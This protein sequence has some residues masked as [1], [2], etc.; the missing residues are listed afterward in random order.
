MIK[1]D[2]NIS[3]EAMALCGRVAEKT[4]A[5]DE[6]ALATE[7]YK[8]LAAERRD[9]SLPDAMESLGIGTR[10]ALLH[11]TGFYL[12]QEELP[13]L[14]KDESG[15]A[16]PPREDISRS[17]V[18]DIAL[19]VIDNIVRRTRVTDRY[20][21]MEH[22]CGVLEY[23]FGT[24]KTLERNLEKLHLETT[25][26]VLQAIDVYFIMKQLYPDTVFGRKRMQSAWGPSFQACLPIKEVS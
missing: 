6:V 18:S 2:E 19:F 24:G 20:D 10:E 7:I 12:S 26:D 9:G 23:R 16:E 3:M 21:V 17:S 14:P 22:M 25:K 4:G 11:L 8:V 5:N 15:A 13:A 1:M